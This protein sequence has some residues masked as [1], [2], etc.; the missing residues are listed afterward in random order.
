MKFELS[1][2]LKSPC[3]NLWH[4]L[5]GIG[6]VINGQ[7]EVPDALAHPLLAACQDPP[8][9][10]IVDASSTFTARLRTDEEKSPLRLIC[11]DCVWNVSARCEGSSCCGG[12]VPIEVRLN[13]TSSLC[14]K[15]RWPATP[16]Q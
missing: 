14:P 4:S 1:E 6:H 10:V 13:L 2:L 7:L 12:R 5:A 11:V 9:S 8:I 15:G 3:P 16:L